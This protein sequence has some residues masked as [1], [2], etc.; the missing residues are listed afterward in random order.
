MNHEKDLVSAGIPDQ[1][2]LI[3]LVKQL[4][5]KKPI[6]VEIGAYIGR[7]A[8]ALIQGGAEHV[9]SID[10]WSGD[11]TDDSNLKDWR[12][13]QNIIKGENVLSQ[14]CNNVPLLSKCTPLIGD[15]IWW[16]N[17]W[18]FKVDLIFIDADHNYESCLLDI[19][20]WWPHLKT[21]GILCGHDYCEQCPGVIQ[22]VDE[23]FISEMVN[24]NKVSIGGWSIWSIYKS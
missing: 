9:Y 1:L 10:L 15:S 23:A 12:W 3:R 6:C 20:A 19:N 2:E 22:A 21:G 24:G 7:T 18:P 4:K 5:N 8:S 13:E 11:L 14:Y 16:A 17:K